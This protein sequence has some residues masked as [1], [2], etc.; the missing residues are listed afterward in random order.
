[1]LCANDL[2]AAW[3]GLLYL[4]QL[5]LE[6]DCVSGPAT[7][8]SAG[9]DYIVQRF[10]KQAANARTGPEALANLVEA[11]VFGARKKTARKQM[12]QA[13]ARESVERRKAVA[14]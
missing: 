13:R 12:A 4:G 6:V 8:N 9:V 14:S 5:G 1:M 10:G 2:V 3:G 7:D 11:R